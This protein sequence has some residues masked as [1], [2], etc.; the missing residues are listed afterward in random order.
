MTRLSCRGAENEYSRSFA[1]LRMTWSDVSQASASE[2]A[3]FS[4]GIL[5]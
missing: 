1:A 2:A 4:A 5:G 3:L